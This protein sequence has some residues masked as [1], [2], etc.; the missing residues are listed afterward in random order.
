[1]NQICVWGDTASTSAF[2]DRVSYVSSDSAVINHIIKIDRVTQL[3]MGRVRFDIYVETGWARCLLHKLSAGRRR[4]GWHYRRSFN[5]EQRTGG[6]LSVSMRLARAAAQSNRSAPVPDQPTKPLTVATYN[7]NGIKKKRV[8]LQY[9]L[10]KEEI[11]V[12]GIQETLQQAADWPIKIPG[13]HSY[14]STSSK[15]SSKR[16]VAVLISTKFNGSPVGKS[17][18]FWVMVRIYGQDLVSPLIFCSVYVPWRV[19]RELVL[20]LLPIEISKVQDKYP[21]DPIVIGGDFNMLLPA[22]EK[23]TSRWDTMFRFLPNLGGVPTRRANVSQNSSPRSIDHIGYCGQSQEAVP[24]AIVKQTYDMSDH[25]PVVARI[26]SLLRIGFHEV[27]PQPHT[28]KRVLV[29]ELSDRQSIASSNYWTPLATEFSDMIDTS[30]LITLSDTD[31]QEEVDIMAKRWVETCHLVSKDN[32]LHQKD[33]SFFRPRVP[34]AARVAIKRR[35]KA[36]KTLIT[37][38]IDGGPMVTEEPRSRYKSA[39]TRS[40][41]LL[42]RLARKRWHLAIR[43]SHH[44]MRAHPRKFWQWSSAVA[45]WRRKASGTTVLPVLDK[46]GTLLTCIMDIRRAWGD[47]FAALARDSTGNSKDPTHWAH[48]DQISGETLSTLDRIICIDELWLIISEMKAHKAPG[49]DG[50]PVE[51]LKSCLL[52]RP[53]AAEEAAGEADDKPTPM[54]TAFLALLNF[55][56]SHGVVASAWVES[57]VVAIP[58]KGDMADMNNYRGISLMNTAM[59]VLCVIISRRISVVGE[60][61]NLFS[62]LQA[63]FRTNEESITQAACV[64]DII[65]RRKIAGDQTFALFIDFAKAYDTVPHEGLFAKLARM[66]VRGT[67]LKFIKQLYKVSTFRVRVGSGITAVFSELCSLDCGLRQGCPLSPVLFNIFINDIMDKATNDIG[68]MVPM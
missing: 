43:R 56:Y 20:N 48:I 36:Y 40:K 30:E 8:D 55:A 67:C 15:T 65:E 63:G 7:I 42:R 25:Y 46:E 61:K 35:L 23:R 9:F 49:Q 22:L 58:K 11:E 52:E 3:C 24:V 4:F 33:G 16:G 2:W 10:E 14:V 66:G 51:F 6:Q 47:H 68:V 59:K 1:M 31:A 19:D 54:S 60:E 12:L 64:I 38:E 5:Y 28:L 53:T 57:T 41:K 29:E 32:D 44:Q 45:G 34:R 27:L 21:G 13:F 17:S 26:P 39:K 18:P 37:A 62:P 50:L